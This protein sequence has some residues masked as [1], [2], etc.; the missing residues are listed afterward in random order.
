MALTFSSLVP[1]NSTEDIVHNLHNANEK[2]RDDRYHPAE[3]LPNAQHYIIHVDFC[4]NKN[5]CNAK[6][7][8]KFVCMTTE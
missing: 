4:N 7:E 6:G 8:K 3:N 2:R 1:Y 5:I